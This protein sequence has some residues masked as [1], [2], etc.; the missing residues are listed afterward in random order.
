MYALELGGEDDRFAAAEAGNAAAGIE[1]IASG[2]A[3]A[4]DVDPERVRGLAFTRFASEVVCEV[5]ADVDRAAA[6]LAEADLG[7]ETATAGRPTVAVRAR[8]VRGSAGVET[9]LAERRLGSVLVDRGFEV[10]LETPDRELRAIFADSRCLL[11]WLVAASVRD[12][13]AR[14]PTHKPYFQPGSMDPLEARAIANLAGAGPG[15]TILDPMCGTG[16]LVIEAGLVGARVLAM[17]VQARMVR[18]T[19]ENARRYLDPGG[20]DVLRGDARSL[21]IRAGTVDAAAFDVPYGRQSRV[22]A[23]D[24]GSLLERTLSE[25]ATVTP[26]AVVVADRPI[27]GA[28]GR[29]GWSVRDHF[30]RRVHRSLVRHVTVLDR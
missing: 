14:K 8:D 16:G 20:W 29:A 7:I 6:C 30:E 12:F 25:V 17:D 28:A 2:L 22:E 21:P 23:D 3:T 26:V 15:T 5:T 18:G 9:R 27:D 24:V 10:D 13:G 4:G 19:V 1:V 11:G